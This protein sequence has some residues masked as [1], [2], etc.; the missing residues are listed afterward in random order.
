MVKASYRQV[1]RFGEVPCL[2]KSEIH[3][4]S[5]GDFR[6]RAGYR[7][8]LDSLRSNGAARLAD[9]PE[10]LW[11]TSQT[12]MDSQLD[13]VSGF[14]SQEEEELAR[15]LQ[16]HATSALRLTRLIGEAE[17]A[18]TSAE[19]SRIAHD[20]HDS[21]TQCL[22]GIYTQLE[23]AAHLRQASP[24]VADS[25][26]NKAKELSHW[27]IQEVRRL[28]AALQ[29]DVARHADLAGNLCELAHESSCEA[30]TK[31]MCNFQPTG[32]LVPPDVGYQL[33][34]IAREA[35]GNALRYARAKR[36][37]LELGFTELR[38][39]LSIED[40][41]VGFRPGHPAALN[42]FG[43]NAMRQRAHRIQ[44]RFHLR[45]SPGAGTAIQISVH[46]PSWSRAL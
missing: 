6:R 24:D 42:G 34:Q 3:M 45:S 19:R 27:G 46:C 17:K 22:T 32:R 16:N 41:G 23:A 35:I 5:K 12:P 14:S 26:V 37:I 4:H 43:L 39:K 1:R 28:V 40:D 10:P 8:C 31:V 7:S 30:G 21:L 44:A 9:L 33:F 38:V 25:C 29:P 36:V 20:L 11:F 18:A 2:S 13:G 15:A